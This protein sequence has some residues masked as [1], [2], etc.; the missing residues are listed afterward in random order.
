MRDYNMP[1][2][3]F[4]EFEQ[5]AIYMTPRLSTGRG[6]IIE[7][8]YM[9]FCLNNKEA[10]T[11]SVIH[12]HPNE[13]L[14]FLLIGK[15]NALVGRDRRIVTPGTFIH[16]PPCGQHQMVATEDGPLSYLYIKEKTWSVVGIA[17]DEAIPDKATSLEEANREFQE[18]DWSA[19]EGKSS[20]RNES[21]TDQGISSIRVEGL[22]NCYYPILEDLDAPYSSADRHYWVEGERL[23]FGFAELMPSHSFHQSKN[24]HEQFIY[25]LGGELDVE[26]DGEKRKVIKGD[27]I[28]VPIGSSYRFTVN[29][30]NPG[31]YVTFMS[32]AY[33]ESLVSGE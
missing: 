14:I 2:Y 19:G 16:I 23:V 30:T 15:I 5:D 7:G 22:H 28:Q 11:G 4:E 13:L 29:G 3:R 27:I 17:A 8:Q 1:F 6:P 33:L 10:G 9:Y 24:V 32:T 26:L 18:A 12:Y 21:A 25:I 20:E 31:R